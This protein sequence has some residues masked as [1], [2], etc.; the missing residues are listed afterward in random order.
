LRTAAKR[1]DALA[2][3][4]TETEPDSVPELSKPK[5]L[6]GAADQLHALANAQ[7]EL[8]K[9]AEAAARGSDPNARQNA[10]KELVR[11]QEQ[12][13]ERGRE[14]LQKLTRDKA[15][16]SAR[17][18]RTALDKM[19]AARDDLEKG[20]PAGRSQAEA[21]DRLDVARDRLDMA[22][23]QAGRQ[24]ADEKRRRLADQV[25]ALLE[26][27]H[28]AVA[29]AQ[30]IHAEVAKSKSWNR[31]LLATYSD[32]DAVREKEI[33]VEIR[34]LAS[35]DF[36][37]L[38]VFV[39][40]LTDSAS[41][42]DS[43]RE[44]IK[45][46]CDDAD[47]AA[48]FDAELEAATDAKVLRPMELALRRLNQLAAALKPDEPKQQHQ[49]KNEPQEPPQPPPPANPGA[50]E[51]VIPPLAQL[52]VLR[53]LQAELNARTAEFAKD[54]PNPDQLTD[55]QK[56][57][58]KELEQAQHEITELFEK[59]AKLF[60]KKKQEDGKADGENPP[61]A[62]DPLKDEKKEPGQNEKPSR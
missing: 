13:I 36:A 54:H 38:P 33:A 25:K 26:R 7:D 30:R 24:L 18:A 37:T 14:L 53:A 41:A 23:A 8:R 35:A 46:R 19:E 1:L 50:A 60:E 12:L 4:L 21:V 44:R 58:L 27:Q 47:I 29:E 17:D 6:K 11:D 31:A 22:A 52:R 16:D 61:P 55:D 48:A 20:L 62:Q 42:I 59:M 51:D 39:R 2:G 3:A 32:L 49:K 57:E 10:L 5:K 34:K 45:I 9:R 28:A 43:A 56:A 15:D 40:L